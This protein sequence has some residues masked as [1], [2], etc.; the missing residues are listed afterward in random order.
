MRL[1][2]ASLANIASGVAEEL[3]QE[4]LSRVL[5]NVAN[6]NMEAEA[7]RKIKI[8]FTFRPTEGRDMAMIKI[9][10][11][12]SLA[13]V[14]PHET[15]MFFDQEKGERV[16]LSADRAQHSLFDKKGNPAKITPINK[17]A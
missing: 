2:K 7:E 11:K 9:Q 17:G 10:A 14:K 6:P 15:K 3:F 8:E 4:E 12:S 5:D 1:E 16:A 13:P